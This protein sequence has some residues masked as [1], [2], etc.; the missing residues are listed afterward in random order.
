MGITQV[1]C[2]DLCRN[3]CAKTYRQGI[4]GLWLDCHSRGIPLVK[5]SKFVHVLV[6]VHPNLSCCQRSGSQRT[7]G[8]RPG[9]SFVTRR[10][11]AFISGHQRNY[12]FYNRPLPQTYVVF[13]LFQPLQGIYTVALP[14]Y[15]L[16]IL[17]HVACTKF[18][19]RLKQSILEFSEIVDG[20]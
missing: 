5:V 11:Q 20:G 13:S 19:A 17:K 9:V 6:G 15:Y 3:I 4:F 16:I 18:Q 10:L 2:V 12:F 1:R 8:R 14:S 7:G